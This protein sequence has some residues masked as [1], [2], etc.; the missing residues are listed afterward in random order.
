MR[1]CDWKKILP[2]VQDT[3]TKFPRILYPCESMA[4]L[5]QGI[6]D[7][8]LYGFLMCDVEGSDELVEELAKVNFPPIF[9]KME[10]TQD[11]LSD[12]MKARYESRSK[13]LKQVSLI[14]TFRGK[15]QLLHTCLAQY[16]LELGLKLTN[17]QWFTQYLGEE[18]IKPFIEKVVKMRIEATHEN[19][20][21][22]SNTA[23]IIG[24]SGKIYFLIDANKYFLS[25][26]KVSRKCR[27]TYPYKNY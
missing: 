27:E 12:Y 11:H 5:L 21:T 7:N 8:S 2:Q 24:N 9:T 3:P 17:V 4:T 14:Q 10:M 1:E 6:R 22:K 23:K 19:D 16:Y 25:L 15:N 18:A 20:T 13:K 26:R